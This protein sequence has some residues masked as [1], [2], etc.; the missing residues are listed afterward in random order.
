[1]DITSTPVRHVAVEVT[2]SPQGK[3]GPTVPVITVDIPK[4]LFGNLALTN[5]L[6]P[7]EARIVAA[8]L[9]E[10]AGRAEREAARGD[11]PDVLAVASAA[12]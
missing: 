5:A 10:A 3:T 4:Y 8:K 11:G 12:T 9:V 6:T 7:D 2:A 1:M